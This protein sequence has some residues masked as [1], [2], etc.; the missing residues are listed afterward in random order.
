VTEQD[1]P[2]P[3]SWSRIPAWPGLS[4]PLGATYSQG[5]PMLLASDE[6]GRSQRG[7]NNGYC[8][9]NDLSWLH[10]PEPLTRP[11][12]GA[13][14]SGTGRDLADFT[15]TLIRFRADHPVFRRRRLFTGATGHGT[16]A[17]LDDIAW[18]TPADT[19]MTE[20]DWEAGFAKSL[21]VLLNGDAIN[22][23]GPRAEPI[24]DDSFLLLFNAAEHEMEFA[25]PPP[26]FG[27]Q[28]MTVLDTAD[29][30]PALDSDAVKPGDTVLLA[31]RALRVLRRA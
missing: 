5:V 14:W 22:E 26:G 16:E 11:V 27:E 17:H 25:I 8:Q 1:P 18:L 7:N 23:P 19:P 3:G 20:A 24:L 28:W 10:W 21:T 2:P 12:A 30:W 29:P 6:L 13:G 31:D 9:D 15:R 4:Y